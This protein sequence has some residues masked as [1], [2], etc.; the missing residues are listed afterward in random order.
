MS[1]YQVTK[2]AQCPVSI[3]GWKPGYGFRA[4]LITFGILLF[5]FIFAG[6]FPF[7]EY[8][9]LKMDL[10]HA[11]APD[12]LET[13]R[14]L[15]ADGSVLYSWGGML[16]GNL[17]GSVITIAS[18]PFNLL[19]LLFPAQY[20][21]EFFTVLTLFKIPFAAA[22]FSHYIQKRF[23][24]TGWNGVIFSVPYA[25]CS[26]VTAFH[27]NI[28]WIDTVIA[29]P[30]VFLG[31]DRLIDQHDVRLYCGSLIYAIV[32]SYG[33]A[34]QLCIFSALYF[35]CGILLRG[36]SSM[37][38]CAR[39]MICSLLAAGTCAIY[40]LTVTDSFQNSQYFHEPFPA[41]GL[42]F[43][44]LRFLVAHFAGGF[45]SVR[46][47]SD[48]VPNLYAGVLPVLMLPLFFLSKQIKRR[49]KL[50]WGLFL[51]ITAVC[52][53]TS[54]PTFIL[55]GLHFPVMF[56]HRYSYIY[57]FA[58]LSMAARVYGVEECQGKKGCILC[59]S[60]FALTI[61]ILFLLC[62]QYDASTTNLLNAIIP[63][64]WH[65]TRPLVPGR[66]S[67]TALAAN[68]LL[69]GVYCAALLIR[70][71]VEKPAANRA[72][73]VV[74]ALVVCTE[75]MAG[76]Y[77]GI[78][79]LA[80]VEHTWYNQELYD[81]MQSVTEL[82]D[83]E[84]G[85]YRAEF[86]RNRTQSDGRIYGYNGLSGFSVSSGGYPKGLQDL[87]YELGMSSSFNNLVWSEP[88]PVL[89]ALFAQRYLLSE[90]KLE[91][92]EVTS[93]EYME[94][95]GE[96]GI[97]ENPHVLPVGFAVPVTALEWGPGNTLDNPIA[98]QSSLFAA[99][100]G[101]DNLFT[102]IYP[103][104][105]Q[106]ENLVVSGED[107]AG[108]YAFCLPE[109][110]SHEDLASGVY[111]RAVFRYT[112]SQDSFISLTLDCPSVSLATA[113]INGETVNSLFVPW[114]HTS[115]NAGFAKSGDILEVVLDLN[116]VPEGRERDLLREGSIKLHVAQLDLE[117]F[118]QGIGM[119]R[120][121]PLT[122]TEYTSTHLTGE[123]LCEGSCLLYTSIPY[124]H[125]WHITVDGK[126]VRPEQFG[127]ALTA[128]QLDGGMHTVEFTYQV[129][130]L[131]IGAAA[132]VASLVI[133]IVFVHGCEK[134]RAGRN[135][136]E[137]SV[138][139]HSDGS[140]Q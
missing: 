123:I 88:S 21:A 59:A 33:T 95:H 96:I 111:P 75:A 128:I 77:S 22:S 38:Q 49:E 61:V 51:G 67:L 130:I 7:G 6:I 45:P 85:F 139:H 70:K 11:Y 66:L 102:E 9:L 57:S 60:A 32:T 54:V 31:I 18:S 26:F 92:E 135:A 133:L 10:L 42:R 40:L 83:K 14:C 50:A 104:L 68:L 55:H 126:A 124:D 91:H 93:F 100:T 121:S 34:Y 1:I 19:M 47:Y 117:C 98:E 134:K 107:I 46:F 90:G 73:L 112:V 24:Y 138:S 74:L 20:Q 106:S 86:F 76:T 23:S 137:F 72:A 65:E 52:L 39:F 125:N 99:L 103:D 28:M 29:L 115:L 62:P 58:L 81:N 140:N 97:Y 16:G 114:G 122:V 116:A 120:R 127:G 82:L 64:S 43:S 30:L 41:W 119:L 35:L 78:H 84:P 94:N 48:S 108:E 44:P 79:Y 5:S 89:S 25:L 118:E 87:L 2:S 56:P 101:L 17:L 80:T 53:L 3:L 136:Y 132:S 37:K 12:Y 15:G 27:F 109:Y 113:R 4:Y 131:P 13:L 105:F 63:G 110:I 69:V 71:S 8:C 129:D 36:R